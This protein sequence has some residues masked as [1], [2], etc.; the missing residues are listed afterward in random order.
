MAARADA[1]PKAGS[2]ALIRGDNM[3]STPAVPEADR[4]RTQLGSLAN[5]EKGR[6]EIIDDDPRHYTFSNMF[7]VASMS[8]P[9]EQVA[10]GKNIQYVLE[11]LRA[12]GTS[13]WRTADHD[14][15]ALIMDGVV[16][17]HLVKLEDEAQR[18]ATGKQGSVAVQGAP[19]GPKMGHI[20]ARRGHMVLLPAGAAYQFRSASPG[21]ILMQTIAGDDTTYK[22]AEICQTM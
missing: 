17:T 12:E 6:V 8:K 21:V 4:W 15:F 7:Q 16:E 1:V 9:Y 11:V 18:A 14:Q 3:T 10:V 22:W 5:F 2:Q 19:R 13:A 20:V